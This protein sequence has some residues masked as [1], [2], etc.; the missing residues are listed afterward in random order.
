MRDGLAVRAERGGVEVAITGGLVI[1]PV[2]G[3]RYASIGVSGGRIVSVGRAGNPD[4][5]DGID[6]VLDTATAVHDASGLIVTPGGIDT[7]VHW[8]SPQVADAA[9]A[10]GL[11][12]LVIQ[13]PGPVWNLGCNPPE[14]LATAWAALDAYPLNAALARPRLLRPAGPGPA[15]AARRRGGAEDPR[16]RLRRAGPDP[17]R[18]RHLRRRGRP[19]RDPHRRAQ[20]GAVGGGHLRGVR[21]AHDPRVPHRGL[22]R[23]SRAR[24]A[25]ARRPRARAHLVHQ[26]GAP[27]RRRHRGRGPRDG[28]GRAPARPERPQRRPRHP[29]PARARPHDGRRRRPARPRRD[30]HDVLGLAGHGARGGGRAPRAA[31]RR[32]DEGRPRW[33]GRARQRARAAPHRQGH[34]QP[35]ARARPGR[36]RR[37]S[38]ARAASRT[39]CSGNRR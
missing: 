21:R 38:H 25:R 8:L 9:L 15:R 12:T 18:A 22:R 20:R 2:L 36:P 35:G 37:R 29:R 6:V 11:T 23:R 26:P 14:L 3:V 4:T 7:H 10:G 34:D 19:A 27:V 30:P 17:D 39:R 5:M 13:D 33:G 16:G 1:D 28:R 31:E 32:L 24:P